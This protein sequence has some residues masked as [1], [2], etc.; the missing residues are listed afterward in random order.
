M[1]THFTATPALHL[2]HY[3]SITTE[4]GGSPESLSGSATPQAL[5]PP[6]D[7]VNMR[8]DRRLNMPYGP[9]SASLLLKNDLDHRGLRRS[10]TSLEI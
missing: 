2:C 5:P 4:A 9:W 10:S 3:A 8:N 6:A 7:I 1:R